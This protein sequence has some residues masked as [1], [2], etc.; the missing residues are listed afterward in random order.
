[1][2]SR[3]QIIY[4]LS[5]NSKVKMEILQAEIE[6]QGA[7]IRAMKESLKSDPAAIPKEDLDCEIKELTSMKV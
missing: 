2:S 3:E 1:M 5:S 4:E 7:K 6:N